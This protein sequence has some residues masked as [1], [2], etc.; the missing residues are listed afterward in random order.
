MRDIES[1]PFL[2]HT[3]AQLHHRGCLLTMTQKSGIPHTTLW[4]WER[5][6]SRQYDPRLVRTLCEYYRLNQDD[7]WHLIRRDTDLRDAGKSVPVPALGR[8]RRLLGS[9]AGRFGEY[10]DQRSG[11]ALR[12]RERLRV[13]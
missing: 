1:F 2:I 4:R 6:L 9:A 8:G 11:A 5:G 12:R 3:L 13:R 10:P 7:V